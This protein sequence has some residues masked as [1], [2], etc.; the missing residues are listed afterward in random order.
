MGNPFGGI[1]LSRMPDTPRQASARMGPDPTFLQGA[2]ANYMASQNVDEA[3]VQEALTNG[4]APIADELR[5]R[6]VPGAYS[7]RDPRDGW[8]LSYDPDAIWNGVR[9]ARAHDPKAFAQLP[10]TREEYDARLTA[11]VQAALAQQGDTASR[12]GVVARLTGGFASGASEPENLLGAVGASAS[13]RSI[14][15][16]ALRDAAINAR[17]TAMDQQIQTAQRAKAGK[18]TDVGEVAASVAE[19]YAFGFALGGTVK[20]GSKIVEALWDRLPA[21]AR[22][23]W[24]SP[25]A[26]TEADLPDLVEMVGGDGLTEAQR[27]AVTVMRREQEIAAANP[28][29]PN[30]AGIAAHRARLGDAIDAMLNPEA[31]ATGRAALRSSTALG[32]GTVPNV[33]AIERIETGGGSAAT[34]QAMVSPK[35]AV[36]VMQVMPGTGPEAAKLAGLPWD[37]ARFHSDA[38]YNRALGRAYYGKQLEDFGD[39]AKAAAAY[40]AGPGRVRAAIAAAEKAGDSWEAHL[41]A[42]TR[43]Y[44]EQFRQRAGVGDAVDGSD[45]GEAAHRERLFG[46]IEQLQAERAQLRHDAAAG[47]APLVDPATIDSGG[48]LRLA[49]PPPIAPGEAAAT[50]PTSGEAAAPLVSSEGLPD[51]PR[52]VDRLAQDVEWGKAVAS[53]RQGEPVANSP[54]TGDGPGAIGPAALLSPIF[55]PPKGAPGIHVEIAADH[56]DAMVVYRDET[57]A[58]RAALHVPTNAET[59]RNHGGLTTYVEPALRRQGI[60]TRLYAAAREAGLPVDELSGRGD[61][62]PE[63]AQFARAQRADPAAGSDEPGRQSG[64]A[65]RSAADLAAG[66][67]VDLDAFDA[68]WEDPA[69]LESLAKQFDDWDSPGASALSESLEHDLAME[70][71]RDEGL[72]LVEMLAGEKA[73]TRYPGDT[74]AAGARQRDYIAGYRSEIYRGDPQRNAPPDTP[75]GRAG[76]EEARQ[77]IDALSGEHGD[78]TYRLSPEGDEV[79]ARQLLAEL[80]AESN[81]IEALR[82]CLVPAKPEPVS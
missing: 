46:E 10:A 47:D 57:G 22:R 48:D 4:Y 3:R 33:S 77:L 78:A 52:T 7:K 72:A 18:P 37:E 55:T 54:A 58:P 67:S 16:A 38:E 65:R 45:L 14:L 82:A 68:A 66:R 21:A 6:G 61:L 23:R 25:D 79:T 80:D 59:L 42:E 50:A 34:R 17:L 71:D 74:T 19:S 24:G 44:V 27:D 35:G 20:G 29:E 15:Q 8:A 56:S 9:A 13:A 49:E 39:P 1:V 70:A 60:A 32:S 73:R 64:D 76:A 81:H 51:I 43:A 62:T 12:A 5:H 69:Y 41:P 28:F 2:W 75:E 26:V 63:G 31:R 11:P 40:N 53:L 30:G 36:G